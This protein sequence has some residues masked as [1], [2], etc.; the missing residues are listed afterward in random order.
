MKPV[1]EEHDRPESPPERVFTLNKYTLV[2]IQD[3][4]KAYIAAR[5]GI[6][7]GSKETKRFSKKLAAT[8]IRITEHDIVKE[9]R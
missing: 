6:V 1:K 9:I 4:Y 3:A 2:Q 8:K 5:Q 7:H